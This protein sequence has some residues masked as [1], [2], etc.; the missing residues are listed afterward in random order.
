MKMKFKEQEI[1][2]FTTLRENQFVNME[3]LFVSD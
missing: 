3:N 1:L 2:Y